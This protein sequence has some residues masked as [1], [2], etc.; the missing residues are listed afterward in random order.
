[1]SGLFV[2]YFECQFEK[3]TFNIKF[4]PYEKYP[5]KEEYKS[6]RANHANLDFSRDGEK[7]FYWELEKSAQDDLGGQAI[8]ISADKNPRVFINILERAIVHRLRSL[9]NYR[10]YKD[11]Y[12]QVWK[13]ISKKDLLDSSFDGL[14]VNRQICLNTYYRFSD[15]KVS[16]GLVISSEIENKFTW[17]RADFQKHGI[18]TSTLGGKDNII[19]ANKVALKQYL[20]ALGRTEEYDER[21]KLLDSNEQQFSVVSKFFDWIQKTSFYLPDDNKI[22]SISKKYLPFSG[23]NIEIFQNPKRYYFGSKTNEQNRASYNEQVKQ[24]KPFTYDLFENK[25]VNIGVLCPKQFEGITESFISKLE[26]ILKNELHLRKLDF[27]FHYVD[28]VSLASY[29]SG[30]YN[31]EL[32]SCQVVMIVVV[33]EHKKITPQASPYFICKAKY[34]GNGIPTQDIQIK[35]IKNPNQY[36]L[37]NIA[38]NIYAKLGGTAWTIEKED[39]RRE[40][41]IVGIGSSTD[42]NGKHILGIAQVFNS[43]GKYLVGDCA[44][45]SS[46][47][48]YAENL[49]KYLWQTLNTIIDSQIN[50]QSEFRLIFH[51]Y[52]GASNKY[53]IPAIN[54]VIKKFD[55]LSFKYAFLHLGYGHNFRVFN[56]D[57]NLKVNRGTFIKIDSNS[58][59]IH[60]VPENSLP[61]YVQLDRRSTFTDLYYLSKQV[62][63][64]SS[65]SHRSY[66]PAKRTVTITYPSLMAALTEKLKYV[67]GW[68][69]D[70]LKAISEKLWFI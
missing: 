34:L 18:D 31:Q 68:D 46:F 26:R 69:Y 1:M 22:K 51:L 12:S 41:L 11:S 63:W 20:L 48:N 64:F 35:N 60:F 49:E 55:H 30:L 37:N 66:I 5:T 57:G 7:L 19:Y 25:S 15:G 70:R 29:Q 61:L 23:I 6:L 36:I 39:K 13:I 28:D 43:D 40:E 58:A 4:L 54:S 14:V 62:Y 24:Y 65:L 3:Y 33:E 8:S 27:H 53:E 50:K 56:N 17:D 16:F 38:L 42:E 21:I 44:P 45:L 67:D 32:L 9:E 59:L 52:K 10:V 2:N 47:D